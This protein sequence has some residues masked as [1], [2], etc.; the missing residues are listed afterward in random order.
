[1]KMEKDIRGFESDGFA[2]L[3]FFSG[4]LTSF[5]GE[6]VPTTGDED[7]WV[8]GTIFSVNVPTSKTNGEAVPMLKKNLR[9][10]VCRP[11]LSTDP[12]STK[13]FRLTVNLT[14]RAFSPKG[15][16]WSRVI[17]NR[18][19]LDKKTLIILAMTYGRINIENT[20]E[21]A[22]I[23]THVQKDQ[24][25]IDNRYKMTATTANII[26]DNRFI[27]C[28]IEVMQPNVGLKW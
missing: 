1:M 24:F 25:R 23:L 17:E 26:D 6:R 15:E 2:L 5:S 28:K 16:S 8:F 9:K 21:P 18:F 12:V 22:R 4:S 14:L 13:P 19:P 3:S 20:K 27:I 10:F 7:D 11:I